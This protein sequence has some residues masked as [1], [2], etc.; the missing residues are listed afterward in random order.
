M[1]TAVYPGSFDPITFG[2]LDVIRRASV[3]FD[4]VTVAIAVNESK[5]CLFS[6]EERR[7]MIAEALEGQP[8]IEVEIFRGMT[9]DFVRRKGSHIILRGIRTVADFEYEFSLALT[10]RQMAKDIETL[11]VMPDQRYAFFSSRLAREV[12]ALGG[13]V[14]EFT[15]PAIAARLRARLRERRK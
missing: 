8:N 5:Q 13:P 6:P 10:N 11:F 14:E 4:T 12:A 2:H 9:V 1:R 3:L 7:D 15:T